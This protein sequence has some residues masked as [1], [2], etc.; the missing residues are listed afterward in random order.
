M[1]LA[2]IIISKKVN[3]IATYLNIITM[4]ASMNLTTLLL[5]SLIVI[6]GVLNFV[7]FVKI[8]N[9][10]DNVEEIRKLLL[11]YFEKRAFSD[12][13][14]SQ[15]EKNKRDDNVKLPSDG[16]VICKN[17]GAKLRRGTRYCPNCGSLT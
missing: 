13:S 14:A 2:Y 12:S 17:C 16:S 9:M 5:Y 15:Q 3:N 1:Y 11:E 7:L 4:S 8:W 6:W 10:T